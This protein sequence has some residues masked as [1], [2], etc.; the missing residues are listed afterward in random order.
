MQ[1]KRGRLLSLIGGVVAVATSFQP[2]RADGILDEPVP[3]SGRLRNYSISEL[4]ARM[5]GWADTSGKGEFLLAMPLPEELS[6]EKIDRI[7]IKGEPRPTY[8]DV[9]TLAL[10]TAGQRTLLEGTDKGIRVT[11]LS[12]RSYSL[13]ESTREAL[14][15]KGRLS[16]E[17]IEKDLAEKGCRLSEHAKLGYSGE[18]SIFLVDGTEDDIA[19]VS[20][21]LGAE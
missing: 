19:T 4:V 20:R 7:D 9:I 16:L 2:L 21:Y 1:M 13:S 18:T 14:R 6:A 11:Y 5:S 10:Q 3:W 17:G 12:S 8:R 15:Q